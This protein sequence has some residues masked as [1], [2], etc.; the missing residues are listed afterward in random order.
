[1]KDFVLIKDPQIAK[2]FA[3]SNRREILR[4]LRIEELTA[5]QLAKILRKNVSSVAHH[6][7]ALEKAGLIEQTRKSI[8]GNLV[9]KFYRSAAQKF[10]ISY[11]L[12]EGLVPGSEEVATQSREIYEGTVE[13]FS[14]FG[15]MISNEDEEKLSEL[16]ERYSSIKRI[17]YE[18]IISSQRKT[19]SIKLAALKLALEI[20]TS[21]Q[22][23]SD[24]ELEN[25]L[26]Q[27]HCILEKNKKKLGE[28]T[29]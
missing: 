15:Y 1:M 20:L 24:S 7:N 14:S 9:E 17:A 26:D 28:P 4:N 8:R 29:E 18:D 21:L 12:S 5:F 3:D 19:T 2:L 23:R 25:V 6:L 16:I 27:I 22:L 11:T 10:I 13:S